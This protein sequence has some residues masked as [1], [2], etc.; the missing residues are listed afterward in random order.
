MSKQKELTWQES[1][2]TLANRL[3]HTIKWEAFRGFLKYLPLT[4]V[5]IPVANLSPEAKNALIDKLRPHTLPTAVYQLVV[6]GDYFLGEFS[7]TPYVQS[8]FYSNRDQ[9]NQTNI[10]FTYLED[11][12]AYAQLWADNNART[13][14]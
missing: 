9:F 11:A 3:T 12:Q 10:F 7:Q 5:Q 4:I 8:I 1:S 13:I 6:T 14:K 2:H